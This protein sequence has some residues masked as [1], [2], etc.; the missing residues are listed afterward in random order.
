MAHQLRHIRN[1][2]AHADISYQV[3][4]Q[5]IPVLLEFLNAILEYLYVTRDKL[6]RVQKRLAMARKRAMSP[7][8]VLPGTL[9]PERLDEPSDGQPGS[10]QLTGLW[11]GDSARRSRR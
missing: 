6:T 10:Q 3:T 9:L 7:V 4:E 8:N 2:G 1:F 5:D 11:R